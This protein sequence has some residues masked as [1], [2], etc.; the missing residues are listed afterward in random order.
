MTYHVL[1]EP[2]EGNALEAAA[3]E[4]ISAAAGPRPI[5]VLGPDACGEHGGLLVAFQTA[6]DAR[7][8]GRSAD[9]KIG[10]G[11]A[12]TARLLVDT[13]EIMTDGWSVESW[14]AFWADPDPAVARQR[15]PRVVADDVAAYW[16]ASETPAL[17]KQAYI[18]RVLSL[19]ALVPD[20]RLSCEEWAAHGPS[21]FVR[22]NGSAT[23]DGETVR[24]SGVD[25]ILLDGPR[26]RENRI[27]S[28]SP[29]FAALEARAREAGTAA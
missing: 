23:F 27:Y 15:L 11:K 21:V 18:E 1:L 3:M 28:D 8:F 10:Q 19:L 20:L 25:R 2:A 9:L 22:W 6:P 26:V 17:G 7:A 5:R 16:P 14:A 12:L 29:I 4:R 24:F 13:G